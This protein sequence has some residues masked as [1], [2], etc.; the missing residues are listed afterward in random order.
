M[1]H[2]NLL[3]IPFITFVLFIITIGLAQACSENSAEGGL[4]GLPPGPVA[5]DLE[6]LVEM[7][8]VIIVG[9]VV[10]IQP[11]RSVET[12][13]GPLEFNDVQVQIERPL[14]G[15]V[16][17]DL[18]VEQLSLEEGVISP[19]IGPPYGE[20]ERYVLFLTQGEGERYVTVSQ[21]RYLIENGQI[22]SLQPGIVADEVNGMD[23][24]QFINQIEG[25]V[26]G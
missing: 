22:R 13:E 18:I 17:G 12:P 10:G 16:S 23:A 7:S 26:S 6:S 2:P 19:E 14:K 20:G 4:S 1:R 8:P 24:Q 25:I 5:E 15:D 21:G 9:Q 11:G 3:S